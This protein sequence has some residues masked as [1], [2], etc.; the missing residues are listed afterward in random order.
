MKI[1][2]KE[3]PK[4]PLN[5]TDEGTYFKCYCPTCGE[6]LNYDKLPENCPSCNQKLRKEN[7]RE[8][9]DRAMKELDEMPEEEFLRRFEEAN[10][11]MKEY[12]VK[13]PKEEIFEIFDLERT[14]NEN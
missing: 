8:I 3:I 2:D 13:L 12:E 14:K 6:A 11:K 10:R 1:K 4:I 7:M 9:L 5:I